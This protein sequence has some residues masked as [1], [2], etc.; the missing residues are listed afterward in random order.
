MA[1][2][3]AFKRLITI[4]WVSVFFEFVLTIATLGV[5]ASAA[6]GFRQNLD[7]PDI[8]GKLAYNIAAVSR[9]LAFG[10]EVVST[11]LNCPRP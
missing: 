8:P 6:Q 1:S 3:T 4:L 5:T 2:R 11:K 10:E 9:N 7:Y